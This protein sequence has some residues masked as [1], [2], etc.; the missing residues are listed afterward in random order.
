M[1]TL[2]AE[3]ALYGT[4]L[5]P[6]DIT[7]ITRIMPTKTWVRGDVRNRRTNALFDYGCW[8][9]G[10]A[11][12]TSSLESLMQSLIGRLSGCDKL[13]GML[14]A[15]RGYDIE[16]SVTLRIS[17]ETPDISLSESVVKW[18]CML[19]ASLDFDIYDVRG[20]LPDHHNERGADSHNL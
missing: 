18:M 8:K 20:E 6:D 17:G 3:L 12:S 1:T 9:S 14:A 15:E 4:D 5:V 10:T 13:I 16:V 7:A 11:V 19:G 2:V